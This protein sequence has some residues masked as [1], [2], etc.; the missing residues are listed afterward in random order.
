MYGGLD[1]GVEEIMRCDVLY[2]VDNTYVYTGW[3]LC[4][5]NNDFV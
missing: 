5:Q 2:A 4:V 3:S 1:C